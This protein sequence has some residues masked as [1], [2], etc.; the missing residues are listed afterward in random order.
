MIDFIRPEPGLKAE[1]LAMMDCFYAAG[2]T[3]VNGSAGLDMDND[4]DRWL[5]YLGRIERGEEDGFV[6]SQVYLAREPGGQLAG[7]LDIRPTLP[8]SKITYGHMGYAVAPGWRRQGFATQ[9]AQ[10][11]TAQLQKAGINPV[12]V[13]CYQYNEPSRKTLENT[14]FAFVSSHVE[15]ETGKTVLVFEK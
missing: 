13:C 15:P 5:A 4:Y 2:E 3:T 12:V 8:Q 11:G 10:W 7:I 1:V 14:G 9:M 6:P